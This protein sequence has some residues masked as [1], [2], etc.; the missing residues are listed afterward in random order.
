MCCPGASGVQD[1]RSGPV[2]ARRARGV[3]FLRRG[4]AWKFV[5]GRRPEF[6]GSSATAEGSLAKYG[7][8][9]ESQARGESSKRRTRGKEGTKWSSFS[10]CLRL[11]YFK[12]WLKCRRTST[13]SARRYKDGVVCLRFCRREGADPSRPCAVPVSVPTQEPCPPQP[14]LRGGAVLTHHEGS[15]GKISPDVDSSPT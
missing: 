12:E 3:R 14:L 8:G 4:R 9:T 13:H 10:F 5:A 15:A 2:L 6:G 11:A 1:R 7:F